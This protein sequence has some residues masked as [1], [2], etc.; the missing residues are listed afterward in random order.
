MEQPFIAGIV[1]F[2]VGIL[3]TYLG[4]LIRYRG[5]TSLLAGY[6]AERV[7]DEEGLARSAG[8]GVLALGAFSLVTGVLIALFP[9]AIGMLSIAYAGLIIGGTI[10]IIRVSGRYMKART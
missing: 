10:Q 6:R 1:I 2:A 5:K 7:A 8:E 3:I 9:D 4:Y